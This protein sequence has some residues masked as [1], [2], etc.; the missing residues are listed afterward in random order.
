M[1]VLASPPFSV[2]TRGTYT[3]RKG[4]LATSVLVD[5]HKPPLKTRNHKSQHLQSLQMA[6][7]LLYGNDKEPEFPFKAIRGMAATSEILIKGEL[8]WLGTS[9]KSI[10]LTLTK[11][12]HRCSTLFLFSQEQERQRFK[13]R[14][15]GTDGT[16]SDKSSSHF[17]T[18]CRLFLARTVSNSDM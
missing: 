12:C 11:I 16:R 6:E 9:F 14:H 2:R 4:F 17:N 1:G 15:P 10:S 7:L 3:C 8:S 18:L 5:S 13:A